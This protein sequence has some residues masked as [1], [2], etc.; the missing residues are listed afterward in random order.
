MDMDE[1]QAM[2]EVVATQPG[3]KVQSVAASDEF[4]FASEVRQQL[5]EVRQ[6]MS[7]QNSE[8]RQQNSEVRQQMSQQHSE[9]RQQL[10]EVRQQNSEVRQ[11]MSQQNSEVRQQILKMVQQN[12]EVTQQVSLL[13]QMFHSALSALMLQT[14][15]HQRMK[16]KEQH[17]YSV[18][19]TDMQQAKT[20]ERHALMDD[21]CLSVQVVGTAAGIGAQRPADD[22]TEQDAAM[23]HQISHDAGVPHLISTMQS[24]VEQTRIADNLLLERL[25][26]L[27]NS[28]RLFCIAEHYI[29]Y[30]CQLF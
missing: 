23:P 27:A 19:A 13:S 17:P 4:D 8:V 9:V 16:S 6:Q 18:S 20:T 2:S 21:T 5:T 25:E 22:R 24:A 15:E 12:S 28:N 30:F 1:R 29:M 10:A 7:Q 3:D 11:Q 26:Q 14:E